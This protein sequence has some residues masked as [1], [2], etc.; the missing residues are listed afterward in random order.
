MYKHCEKNIKME[1]ECTDV[2]SIV[3]K[4]TDEYILQCHLCE[5]HMQT[6]EMVDPWFDG[7]P[8]EAD[9][10]CFVSTGASTSSIERQV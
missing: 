1:G 2:S 5:L 3:E 6:H 7:A 8:N 9:H 4:T 10:M